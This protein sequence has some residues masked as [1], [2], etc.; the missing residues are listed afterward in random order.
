MCRRRGARA[1]ANDHDLPH[2][3]NGENILWL[4]SKRRN[5]DNDEQGDVEGSAVARTQTVDADKTVSE[6]A[7]Q[8][9]MMLVYHRTTTLP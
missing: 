3:N 8:L 5:E 7:R 2:S 6:T 1:L 4:D 9:F